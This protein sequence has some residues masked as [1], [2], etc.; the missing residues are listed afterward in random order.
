MSRARRW[1]F[2]LNNP[3]TPLD[4]TSFEFKPQYMVWQLELAPTTKTPHY[5]G[6][7]AWESLLRLSSVK[8]MIGNSAHLVVAR[9]TPKENDAYCSKLDSR[10]PG[11]DSGPWRYGNLEDVDFQGKRN[12]WHDIKDMCKEQAPDI[13]IAEIYPRQFGCCK[14]AIYNLKNLYFVP[15]TTHPTVHVIIGPT[16]TGK[17]HFVES[18]YPNA[19][20]KQP[21]SKWWDFY[22]GQRVVYLDEFNGWMPFNNLLLLCDKTDKFQVEY[23]GGAMICPAETIF[24]LSNHR[25]REW[26][27]SNI[28][29]PAFVRRVTQ[30]SYFATQ[31]EHHDFGPGKD[32]YKKLEDFADAQGYR[33]DIQLVSSSAVQVTGFNYV[34]P[35]NQ[36]N[37]PPPQPF[38]ISHTYG[39]TNQGS[40]PARVAK[41][42]PKKTKFKHSS[43]KLCN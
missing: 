30:W 11:E 9:G 34:T 24:I 14:Q 18:Q 2:T 8:S 43:K 39:G 29:F 21:N 35:P 16:E 1:C 36:V 38:R 20:L 10:A 12:D 5:Q 37:V 13:E 19:Y 15:R 25:P 17:T 3:V 33:T 23:K 42:V 26:Y 28:Y 41:L 22:A 6:Y 40:A 4:P 32:G 27:S 7:V 31:E